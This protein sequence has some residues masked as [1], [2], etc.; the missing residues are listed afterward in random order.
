MR[1][2]LIGKTK[3]TLVDIDIQPLK[4]GQKEV[5]PAVALTFKA[6]LANSALNM[7]S[8]TLLGFLYAKGSA[9]AKAQGTLEGVEV[10]SEMPALTPEA[11]NIGSIPWAPEQTGC[12][13]AIYVG[14]T[15]HG[16]IRLKDGT[17][18]IK[19]ITPK[20]GGAV[21]FVISFYTADVDA[22]T[23]GDL[24]VLKSHELDIELQAPELISAKQAD[25]E[26]GSDKKVTPIKGGKKG[27]KL[28]TDAD[29]AQRQADELA[30]DPTQ[31]VPRQDWPLPN[32]PPSPRTPE[33]ALAGA[34]GAK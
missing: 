19:K 24:G 27:G 25:I 16:D 34:V 1:F 30:K 5:L 29:Q 6:T 14:A 33:E 28:G 21:E 17:V 26:S 20:E 12:R 9:G 2:E 3:A 11:E 13:L 22:E 18:Q 15:G 10:I 31:V 7:I 32:D 4:N 8:K 23:L